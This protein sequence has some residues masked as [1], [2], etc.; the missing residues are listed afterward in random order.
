[1]GPRAGLT[2]EENLAFAGIQSPDLPAC[3][4]SLYRLSSPCL[5]SH[6]MADVYLNFEILC[7]GQRECSVFPVFSLKQTVLTST[8]SV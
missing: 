7:S 8:V 6:G 2:G 1:M 4:E 3:S 5:R